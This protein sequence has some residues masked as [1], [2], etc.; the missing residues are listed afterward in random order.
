MLLSRVL[1]G[2]FPPKCLQVKL[3]H[4]GVLGLFNSFRQRPPSLSTAMSTWG[5]C[6][7]Q[8]LRWFCVTPSP[9]IHTL[10]LVLTP[11]LQC[12]LDLVTRF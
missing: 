5:I 6:G 4:R 7:E 8:P 10:V 11:P 2:V 1:N 3:I 12:G 9:G